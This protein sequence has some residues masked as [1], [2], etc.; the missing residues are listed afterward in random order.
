MQATQ[1]LTVVQPQNTSVGLAMRFPKRATIW[2]RCC[3]WLLLTGAI[4]ALT[5]HGGDSPPQQSN[6]VAMAAAT[7]SWVKVIMGFRNGDDI[8][9]LLPDLDEAYETNHKS[10]VMHLVPSSSFFFVTHDSEGSS[11]GVEETARNLADETL[12]HIPYRRVHAHIKMIKSIAMSIPQ[13]SFDQL[14]AIMPQH[15]ESGGVLLYVEKD[16]IVRM[17]NDEG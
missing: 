2:A 11:E 16:G 7:E 14:Q 8:L 15:Q 9:Q 10:G 4:F 12:L 13:E 3:V 5:F 1:S 6:L 17:M